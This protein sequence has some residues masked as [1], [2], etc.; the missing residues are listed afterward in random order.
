MFLLEETEGD[1][2]LLKLFGLSVARL[3]DHFWEV[4]QPG[5][6]EAVALGTGAANELVEERDCL[7]TRVFTLVLNHTSLN[8][9]AQR[10]DAMMM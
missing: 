7:L 1:C 4:G 10:Q 5:G 6:V 2:T 8:K 9:M 3:D